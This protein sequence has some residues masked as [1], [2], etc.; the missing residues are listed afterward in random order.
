ML[1]DW[2]EPNIQSAGGG[3]PG[4]P[5]GRMG[6]TAR[7]SLAE[8]GKALSLALLDRKTAEA[9]GFLQSFD[10]RAKV[11]GILALVVAVSVQESVVT[12]GV[13]CLA[14]VLFAG[15]SRIPARRFA[16]VLTAAPLFSAMIIAPAALNVVSGGRPLLTLWPPSPGIGGPHLAITEAG[17]MIAF[18]FVLRTTACVVM[19]VLLSATTGAP[20]LF[21]GLRAVGVP[22]LFV[23][24]LA[25]MERYVEVLVRVAGEI[26][27][28]RISRSLA[29]ETVK[30]ERLRAAAGLGALFR[31]TR[32]LGNAVY[33][34]MI[35][36]GYGGEPRTWEVLRMRAR[37][38]AF[39]VVAAGTAVFLVIF[40]RGM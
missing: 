31:R 22:A 6:R 32:R 18:R 7:K 26:H 24:I 35:S 5:R 21:R 15:M 19:A 9:P 11:V 30:S 25:M 20:R 38:V 23:M 27:L 33:D 2:L 40:R 12:L 13:V 8:L 4:L 39:V 3:T 36:R 34:A 37:D 16:A 14:C 10:P 28:A 1:P 29:P 17:L